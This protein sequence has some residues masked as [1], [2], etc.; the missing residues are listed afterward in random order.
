MLT[1]KRERNLKPRRIGVIAVNSQL[2]DIYI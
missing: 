2:T 1:R